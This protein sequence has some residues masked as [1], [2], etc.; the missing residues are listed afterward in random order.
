LEK[1]NYKTSKIAWG[2]SM[3][4]WTFLINWR[5]WII[6]LIPVSYGILNPMVNWPRGQFIPVNFSKSNSKKNNCPRFRE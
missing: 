1:L 6:K 4:S 2:T 3:T 5:N